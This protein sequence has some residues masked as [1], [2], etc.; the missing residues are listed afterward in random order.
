M[1][2]L[3]LDN[4]ATRK[5]AVPSGWDLCNAKISWEGRGGYGGSSGAIDDET[6]FVNVLADNFQGIQQ[7]QK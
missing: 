7:R 2:N 1:I 5:T 6:N 4:A 3:G